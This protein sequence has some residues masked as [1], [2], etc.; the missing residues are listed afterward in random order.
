M[1]GE[2]QQVPNSDNLFDSVHPDMLPSDKEGDTK[3]TKLEF[4]D[5]TIGIELVSAVVIYK[6]TSVEVYDRI[7]KSFNL[8][9]QFLPAGDNIWHWSEF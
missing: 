6:S 3:S 4:V 8:P 9:Q 5:A 2:T 1:F 7:F